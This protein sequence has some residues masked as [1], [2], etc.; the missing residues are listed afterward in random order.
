MTGALAALVLLAAASASAGRAPEAVAGRSGIA[1]PLHVVAAGDIA[2]DPESPFFNAGVGSGEDCRQMATSDLWVA[3]D[4]VQAV[5]ALGDLQYEDAST[6]QFLAS[7]DPSWG[8]GLDRI[9]PTPGNHEY[10]TPDAQGYFDYFAE[11]AGPGWYSFD[12]GEWHIVSLN[13]T[14]SNVDCGK[15]SLQGT[16]LRRDLRRS[17]A[18]CTLAFFH[19]PLVA[20]GP[21]G[22]VQFPVVKNF[23]TVLDR[24]GAD[25]ILV[26]HQHAYERFAPMTPGQQRD[27]AGIRQFVVGTGGKNTASQ[28]VVAPN[29]KKRV[30]ALGVLH[31]DL[32]AASYAWR[33]E[34]IAGTTR[35]AGSADC[36]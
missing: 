34:S 31:L 17:D 21:T 12:L 9:Y 19:Y 4:T 18:E 35:D 28:L 1:L 15:G 8:R 27:P 3:D 10:R 32:A 24:R 23:W 29:S 33:F 7:F 13:S 20:S 30:R 22:L 25:V 5:L 2:C 6:E 16:W 14:C 36:T 11:R 26:G